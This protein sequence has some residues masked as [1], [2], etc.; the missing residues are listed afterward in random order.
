MTASFISTGH[1]FSYLSAVIVTR[2][3]VNIFIFLSRTVGR[4]G[5]G[6]RWVLSRW[7]DN[8]WRDSVSRQLIAQLFTA[9]YARQEE[10]K[11]PS[12]SPP[13]IVKKGPLA[14]IIYT[15]GE[16][17]LANKGRCISMDTFPCHCPNSRCT[18][19]VTTVGE[20]TIISTQALVFVF[21]SALDGYL[22]FSII[23]LHTYTAN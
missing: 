1:H 5:N 21:G 12:P 9:G 10:M 16:G 15:T 14:Y 11:R 4:R 18:V 8:K 17:G 7:S 20:L 2:Q 19:A 22:L 3:S 6:K 23:T 13:S